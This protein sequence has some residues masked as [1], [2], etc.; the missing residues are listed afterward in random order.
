MCGLFQPKSMLL[1][2]FVSRER[3]KRDIGVASTQAD[4][5]AVVIVYIDHVTS[6]GNDYVLR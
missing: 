5:A 6:R 3:K 1:S 4:R 2:V